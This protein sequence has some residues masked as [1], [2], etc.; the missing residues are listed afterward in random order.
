MNRWLTVVSYSKRVSRSVLFFFVL[1]NVWRFTTYAGVNEDFFVKGNQLYQ[2]EKYSEA[3]SS[4][5]EI[6]SGGNE[7]FEL[8]YNLGNAYFRLGTIGQAILNYERARRLAPLNEDVLHNLEIANF[9]K[10][11]R[12][13]VP[14]RFFLLEIFDDMIE[15]LG[16]KSNLNTFTKYVLGIYYVLMVLM[17]LRVLTRRQV[18]K[19]RLAY[20]VFPLFVGLIL[21][22]ISLQID[23][24]STTQTN[25]AIILM[26]EVDVRGAPEENAKALFSLHEGVKVK[27]QSNVINNEEE[28]LEIELID[29]KSG[30]IIN[31]A[32]ERI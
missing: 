31:K 28:W 26:E 10:I 12:I 21:L 6:I 3:I 11:D 18:L 19:R 17:L 30:W 23:I 32:L 15:F 20:I 2:Q 4:Y 13:K 22:V 1:F 25:E 27:I 29:G 24:F 8:Y 9:T 7:S 16:L 5:Q 14:P